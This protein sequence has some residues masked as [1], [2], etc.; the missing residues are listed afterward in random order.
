ML[1]EN[2]REDCFEGVGRGVGVSLF[3][4]ILPKKLL[5][6]IPRI[7]EGSESTSFIMPAVASQFQALLLC[8]I[9][10]KCSERKEDVR[11][12]VLALVA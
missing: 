2:G 9:Y 1:Q 3:L 11:G 10:G 8:N 12:G 7:Q 6:E 4:H 5:R